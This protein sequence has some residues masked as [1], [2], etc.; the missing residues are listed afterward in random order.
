[1]A[2]RDKASTEAMI[3]VVYFDALSA[4]DYLDISAGGKTEA[5]SAHV[6]ERAADVA[7]RVDAKATAKFGWLPFF[8]ASAETGVSASASSAGQSILS[9][10]L[11]NTI[12]TDYLVQAADD[13][14]IIALRGLRVTALKDS[15]AYMKMY[16]PYMIIAK[17]EES[18]LD[19]ARIDEAFEKAKGYYELVGT[20][21]QNVRRLVLRFNI[22]AFRNN[23]GLADLGKMTLVYHGVRVGQTSE[24]QLGMNAEMSGGTERPRLTAD[25]V[26]SGTAPTDADLLDVYDIILAGV[27]SSVSEVN[28]A[29]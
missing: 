5:T 11:S 12:L 8:G 27:E 18:G 21:R 1:M 19:L 20:D 24:T 29:D 15:M 6:R 14:H 10:T 28:H 13:P 17:T 16:T 7:G 2:G 3:K 9:K 4:S 23:Y 22:A 26:L 25:E